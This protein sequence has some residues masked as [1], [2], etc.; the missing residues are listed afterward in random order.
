MRFSAANSR[1]EVR[2]HFRDVF[3]A[4]AQRRDVQLDHVQ[5]VVQILPEGLGS[6]GIDQIAIG[7]GD[8]ADVDPRFRP[9]GSDALNL[10]GLEES[11]EKPLHSR[12]GFADL[13][14]EHRSAVRLFEDTGAIAK[15]AGET[16][17]YVTEEL[18][19]EQR[20]GQR[21]AVHR[22]ERILSPLAAGMNQP[23]DDLLANAAFSG[24]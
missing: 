8:D 10:T 6:D 24:Q 22:D 7:C 2:Q 9:V 3:G 21:G 12:R 18:G 14:H 19:L 1:E 15:R 20:L 23:R 16:S 11:E 13:V 5:P 4:L 17:S